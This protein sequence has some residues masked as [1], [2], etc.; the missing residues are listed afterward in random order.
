MRPLALFFTLSL[1]L[2]FTIP[3][4]AGVGGS[5]GGSSRLQ[6]LEDFDASIRHIVQWPTVQFQNLSVPVK[7]VCS[8][9]SQLQTIAPVQYCAEPVVSQVCTKNYKGSDETCRAGQPGDENAGGGLTRVVWG[10]ANYRQDNFVTSKIYSTTVCLTYQRDGRQQ[11][12]VDYGLESRQY[13]EDYSIPILST[14]TKPSADNPPLELPF[15]L[16]DCP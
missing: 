12:C 4:W 14:M 10:C 11:T 8:K 7:N 1:T 6:T 16:P 5:A 9:G 2:V 13:A 15:H 3:T